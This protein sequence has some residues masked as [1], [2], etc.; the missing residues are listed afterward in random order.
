MSKP[1][2]RYPLPS[3]QFVDWLEAARAGDAAAL[4]ELLES[5]RGY[6]SL[7]ADRELGVDLRAKVGASDLVQKTFMDAQ[8]DLHQFQGRTSAEFVA[9]LQRVLLNN[10][11][12]HGRQF[13]KAEKRQ[14]RKEVSLADTWA[15]V[16]LPADLSTPSRK[17]SANE[18]DARVQEALGRL[19]EHY[20][21]VV[22]LRNM[23]KLL[24]AEIGRRLGR[25]EE[26]AKKLWGRA[27]LLLK[28][29]LSHD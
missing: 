25:S 7:L 19:P 10:L 2:A 13:R 23:E 26:S 22:L 24:F 4:G 3:G 9:W 15:D 20:R 29:D 1:I 8:A 6:L 27:I 17:A 14:V 16:C 11:A 28:K 12:D 5:C 21:Q 18:D